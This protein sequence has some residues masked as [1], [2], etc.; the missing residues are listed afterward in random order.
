MK[1]LRNPASHPWRNV[2]IGPS[3]VHCMDGVWHGWRV[4]WMV[5][6]MDGVW[7][8][9][10]AVRWSIWVH[11]DA[12]GRRVCVNAINVEHVACYNYWKSGA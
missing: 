9:V 8:G 11:V 4:A 10:V 7:H 5:C 3:P 6:G 1:K 12:C 2:S